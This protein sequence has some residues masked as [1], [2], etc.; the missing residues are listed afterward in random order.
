MAKSTSI[1][2]K[3]LG[4]RVLILPADK[5]GEATTASGIIIPG[6]EGNEKN[7]RGTVVAVGPG[8]ILSDGKRGIME[9]KAGDKVVFKRGYEAEDVTYKEKEYVLIN[10]SSIIG[11]EE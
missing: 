6:K 10:E 2:L 3:L 7:E 4:E 8:R 1:G 9:V 11:I 5:K